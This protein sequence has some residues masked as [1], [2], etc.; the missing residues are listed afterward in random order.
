MKAPRYGSLPRGCERGPPDNAFDSVSSGRATRVAA[1]HRRGLVDVATKRQ[2]VWPGPCAN[3]TS[4]VFHRFR[5]GRDALLDIAD[6]VI[7]GFAFED[8]AAVETGFR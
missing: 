5:Q 2:T 8:I 6:A 7:T 3:L 1:D 4:D